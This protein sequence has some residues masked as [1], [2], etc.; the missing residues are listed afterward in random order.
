MDAPVINNIVDFDN[1][2][3]VDKKRGFLPHVTTWVLAF[4]AT[5]LVPPDASCITPPVALVVAI[6]TAGQIIKIK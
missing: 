6:E 3:L 5:N 1:N 2:N 4:D